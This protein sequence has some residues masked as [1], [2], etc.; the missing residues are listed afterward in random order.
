MS[1]YKVH[2]IT[3]YK[4]RNN[5]TTTITISEKDYNGSS[6]TLIADAS[7]LEITTS[8]DI[9]NIYT[10][11]QGSGAVINLLVTPLT[12]TSLF[13]VDPQKFIVKVYNGTTG[14]TLIWQGF[15]NTGIYQED[16]SIGSG[17][18][19]YTPVQLTCNDGM[20]LFDNLSYKVSETG[21]TYTG[22]QSI[23]QVLQNIF[24]KLNLTF[25]NIKTS[26]DLLIAAGVTNIFQYLTVNN[27]NYLDEKGIAMSCRDVL[28]AIFQPLGLI[29]TFRADKIYFIDPIN[30]SNTNKGKSYNATGGTE[31][32]ASLGG[33][34]D[35]SNKD[36][37]YY[38]TGQSLD[39]V[40]PFNQIN[41]KYDPYTYLGET[42]DFNAVGNF[43]GGTFICM[44]GAT[45][46]WQGNYW[47]NS[48]VTFTNWTLSD[49]AKGYGIK[50]TSI[51]NNATPIYYFQRNLRGSQDGI[52][53]YNFPFS[54]IKQDDNIQIEISMDVYTNTRHYVNILNPADSIIA[55]PFQKLC[56]NNIAIKVGN[57]Y[58]NG[59][60][61]KWQA[62][63][64]VSN[65][66]KVQDLTV[67]FI[68]SAISDVWIPAKMYAFLSQSSACNVG[69]ISGDIDV[70][71]YKGVDVI[72]LCS[73]W[74]GA[75]DNHIQNIM[76]K[77]VG[78]KIV[79]LTNTQI[80]NSGVE[81]ILN[82]NNATTRTLTPLDISLKNGVG[83]YGSSKGAFSSPSISPTGANITGLARTGCTTYYDTA[84]LLGQ[85]LIS[86]Y[87][88][89]RYKLNVNLDVQ[90]YLLNTDKYLIKDSTYL[91]S[92]AFYVVDG[93]YNDEQESFQAE[94][95]EITNTR[96]TL[97]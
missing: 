63:S 29:M 17:T 7:P 89:S 45:P 47:W 90:N 83:M 46:S 87:Y 27:E 32:Y 23:S 13:T 58:W 85:N 72:G 28:N 12:L 79:D 3:S 95:L 56:M 21:V 77:N 70:K 20:A 97:T 60:T 42:Y 50:E 34:L 64:Y 51:L 92:K 31:T 40:Q 88:T 96:D 44:T 10:P 78:V 59:N 36:I 68:N 41:I 26:S 54:G 16:Y 62:T 25:T 33:Y 84:K 52:Y 61:G 4:R 14:G 93:T 82:I 24:S 80:T 71:I 38:E 66:I 65:Y 94:L 69:L 86:Q 15:I 30:L 76:V 49:G 35:I 2:Y 11:T 81:T 19:N 74:Y 53:E 57:N 8:G 55:T 43:S 6:T 5:N 18:T 22:C 9:N 1:S 39:I 48:G 67:P 75:G 73:P 37:K 91:G